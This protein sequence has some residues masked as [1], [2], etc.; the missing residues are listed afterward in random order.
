MLNLRARWDEV[1]ARCIAYAN[2]WE[3][4]LQGFFDWKG[5]GAEGRGV[6]RQAQQDHQMDRVLPSQG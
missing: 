3:R 1:L 5:R 6:A 2:A 4:Y